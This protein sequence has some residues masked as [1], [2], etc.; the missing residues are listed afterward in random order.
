MFFPMGRDFHVC[1]APPMYS[2]GQSDSL[3]FASYEDRI[4]NAVTSGFTGDFALFLSFVPRCFIYS[5]MFFLSMI[6][7]CLKVSD[8]PCGFRFL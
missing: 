1:S 3:F 7:L 2:I 8:S 5:D 4:G 6:H